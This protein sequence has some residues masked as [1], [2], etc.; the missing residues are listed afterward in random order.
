MM[1]KKAS[2]EMQITDK[3]PGFDPPG[4]VSG[5]CTSTSIFQC[6]SPILEW[7]DLSDEQFRVYTWPDGAIV[8][9]VAPLKL[10]VSKSGGHRVFTADG[11]SH[12][13]PSGWNHLYWVVHPGED[14]FKF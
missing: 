12:Y 7:N 8:K 13:I 3:R 1:N 9:L 10:N 11:V 6:A 2:D 14:H 4:C 5:E